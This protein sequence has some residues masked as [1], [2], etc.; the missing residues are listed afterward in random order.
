MA[1]VIWDNSLSIDVGLIDDQHKLWI[2]KF[3]KVS[4]A[5]EKHEGPNQIA[6]TLGFLIDYTKLH[7]DTEEKHMGANNY[8]EFEEHRKMHE[9]LKKTLEDL[10]QDYDEEGATHMLADYL[11]NFLSNWL[12]NH[13]KEVDLKFGKFLQEKGISL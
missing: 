13:I 12:I 3:N 11:N 7:F 2:E 8:P 6:Q 9:E 5:V 10:V 4:E 1:K